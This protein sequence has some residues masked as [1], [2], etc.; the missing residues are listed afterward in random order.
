MVK[1]GGRAT[2]NAY[3]TTFLSLT[4][5]FRLALVFSRSSAMGDSDKDGVWR[6]AEGCVPMVHGAEA[7]A[8]G[9]EGTWL[10]D[11]IS[12]TRFVTMGVDCGVISTARAT[13]WGMRSRLGNDNLGSGARLVCQEESFPFARIDAVHG[14]GLS[15]N[16]RSRVLWRAAPDEGRVWEDSGGDGGSMCLWE[17]KIGSAD[18]D[19]V[20]TFERRRG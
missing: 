4:H 19:V 20:V 5:A 2:R 12:E 10:F 7:D 9:G 16:V 18:G 14:T 13:G 8:R 1:Q 3:S 6:T 11:S 17:R 15:N